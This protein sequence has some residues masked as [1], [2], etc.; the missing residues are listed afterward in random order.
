VIFGPASIN[1]D[2][3]RR[4]SAATYGWLGDE[5]KARVEAAELLR[6]APKFVDGL[7]FRAA[8]RRADLV[9]IVEGLRKAGLEV[10]DPPSAK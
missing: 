10:P 5:Q 8:Y 7:L 1:P 6:L 2:W 3:C 9:R 4:N